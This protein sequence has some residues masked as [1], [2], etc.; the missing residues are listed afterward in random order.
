MRLPAGQF[1]WIR[2]SFLHNSRVGV[3]GCLSFEERSTR[4]PSL[5]KDSSEWIELLEVI[6]DPNGRPSFAEVIAPKI[7][8]NWSV[9]DGQNVSR[10]PANLLSTQDEIN[11]HLTRLSD[12]FSA[13][14]VLVLDITSLPKRFFCLLTKRLLLSNR[15]SNV[16]AT[17]TGAGTRG[18]VEAHLAYDPETPQEL[19]GF[20][21]LPK[22][23]TDI[24]VGSFGFEA[25]GIRN[26]I[27]MLRESSGTA[28]T[29][30]QI[31][32]PYPP[33]G[34]MT[35][36]QWRTV[37]NITIPQEDIQARVEVISSWDVELLCRYF[38]KWRAGGRLL[39]IPCGPKAHSL[40][41][42]VFATQHQDCGMYYSQPKSYHPDYTKGTGKTWAYV[43]KWDGIPCY[44]R[45]D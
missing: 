1:E 43:L 2:P 14:D 34:I 12:S 26:L 39:F 10:T 28:H 8:S 31:V 20:I 33:N 30:M 27:S 37:R 6:D 22:S 24:I 38:E 21:A 16:I 3:L 25:L 18:Y 40:A 15:W 35:R 13:V 29:R 7:D 4:V 17:Y 9:V 32:L 36:R 45:P 19:P 23:G 42:A 11:K 5:L 44:G 41:M